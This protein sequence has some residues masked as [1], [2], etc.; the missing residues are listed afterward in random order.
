MKICSKFLV[1]NELV[2]QNLF[3]CSFWVVYVILPCYYSIYTHIFKTQY[4]YWKT[5]SFVDDVTRPANGDFPYW[6]VDNSACWM[7]V[8]APLA[9]GFTS[10]E[11]LLS[12]TPNVL[13]FEYMNEAIIIPVRILRYWPNKGAIFF[14]SG[15][16]SCRPGSSRLYPLTVTELSPKANHLWGEPTDEGKM[17]VSG[18]L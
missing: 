16:A 8:D 1:A 12:S 7:Q 17:G 14:P 18:R 10:D 6:G 15:G 9:S 4:V 13:S 2:F 3:I 5:S 11:S